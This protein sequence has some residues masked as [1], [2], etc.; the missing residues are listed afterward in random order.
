MKYLPD[1]VPSGALLID[2]VIL[3]V[4]VTVVALF[5]AF[6]NGFQD[7]SATVA[8]MIACG[9]A[10]PR[11]GVLF[12]SA[13]GF[14]GALLGGSAVAFTV[15]GLID[16]S[17][18]DL[19]VLALF[20]AVL[21]AA[22]WN[23]ITWR[24][25]LPSSSTQALIGGMVGAGLAAAGIDS[26]NWGIDAL[27]DGQ[28]TGMVKVLTFL[29]LSVAIGFGSGYL[30]KKVSMLALRDA[31]LTINRP[32]RRAQYITTAILSFAHGS[33]D[34]QKQMGVITIALF[35][36]GLL[37]TQEIPMWV[38]LLTATAIAVGTIGGGWRIMKTLGRKIIRLHPIDSL[39]SQI[40][41]SSTII[42]STLAGAP[43]SST[44]VVASS[45]M[46]VGTGQRLRMVN[47]SVG[48]HMVMSWVL[49]IP[50]TAVLSAFLFN[51]IKLLI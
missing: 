36:S 47:W 37:A 34:A 13:F 23:L 24:F 19:M 48:K 6:T 15:E 29:I 51:I 35:T 40:A 14:I 43:I 1:Y 32:I 21:S 41:S 45:V 26:I 33:N 27:A 2:L 20:S 17:S 22:S 10:T 3:S 16:I 31:K 9:A 28:L 25:G 44:Q 46:G 8:T 50:S 18:S 12:S 42:I 49:T 39:D 30:M 5:F 11:T 7:S 4:L 38:R